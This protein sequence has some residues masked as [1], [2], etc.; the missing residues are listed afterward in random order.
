[1]PGYVSP[2]ARRPGARLGTCGS[3]TWKLHCVA[4]PASHWHGS[5]NQEP[6]RTTLLLVFFAEIPTQKATDSRGGSGVGRGPWKGNAPAP[7]R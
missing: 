5:P 7:L 4:V 2:Q 3:T 6:P 1:M